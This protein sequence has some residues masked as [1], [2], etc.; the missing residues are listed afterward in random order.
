[1]NNSTTKI[2]KVPYNLT[3]TGKGPHSYKPGRGNAGWTMGEFPTAQA[4]ARFVKAHPEAAMPCWQRFSVVGGE[5]V[6]EAGA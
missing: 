1:M 6:I 2:T 4:A 5:L 3:Y